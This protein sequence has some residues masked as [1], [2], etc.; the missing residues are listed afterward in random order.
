M[1]QI[2]YIVY[3]DINKKEESNSA[4]LLASMSEHG[5]SNKV[6]EDSR[7]NVENNQPFLQKMNIPSD[8]NDIQ[9][10][11][12]QVWNCGEIGFDPNRRWNK[13][14]CTYKLFQ[15]KCMWKVHTWDWAPL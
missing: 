11:A 5:Q 3:R 9:P 1:F 4:I 6:N 10:R 15:G 7:Y 8:L 2:F 14:I 13:V 12:T